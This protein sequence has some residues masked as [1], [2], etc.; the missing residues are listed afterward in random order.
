MG[1]PN[2]PLLLSWCQ[3]VCFYYLGAKLSALLSWCQIVRCQIVRCQIVR[4]Q[5]VLQSTEWPN[6]ILSKVKK[7]SCHFLSG[8][9]DGNIELVKKSCKTQCKNCSIQNQCSIC[10]QKT[11]ENLKQVF[12][13]IYNS[14]LSK[15]NG[16]FSLERFNHNLKKSAFPYQLLT[17]YEDLFLM[18]LQTAHN[19]Y[20]SN[21]L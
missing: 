7:H 3:I 21:L 8:A 16:L 10:Q 6:Y 12:S 19:K 14:D 15:V 20:V 9:L 4:C 1:V 17:N 5:I 13:L 11:E 18:T 2:C